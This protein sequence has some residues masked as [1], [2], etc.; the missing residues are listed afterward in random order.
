MVMVWSSGLRLVLTI[1][2]KGK[3]KKTEPEKSKA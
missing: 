1:Q 3:R 2:T